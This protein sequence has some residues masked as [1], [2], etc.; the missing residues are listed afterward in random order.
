MD[1]NRAEKG[2]FGLVTAEFQS[3]PSRGFPAIW[4]LNY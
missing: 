1:D 3:L 4:I 2:Y